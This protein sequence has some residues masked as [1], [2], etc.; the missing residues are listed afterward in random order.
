MEMNRHRHFRSTQLFCRN[1]P[2]ASLPSRV[3]KER[4]ERRSHTAQRNL[5]A[6]TGQGRRPRYHS[7]QLN[8]ENDCAR[9]DNHAPHDEYHQS[10]TD[11][12]QTTP[13]VT[14]TRTPPTPPRDHPSY[15]YATIASI[16]CTS[17]LKL[18]NFTCWLLLASIASGSVSTHSS[19]GTSAESDVYARM[20][21]TVGSSMTGRKVTVE[22]ICLRI[23]RISACISDSGLAEVL[24]VHCEITLTVIARFVHSRL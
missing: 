3:V 21:N 22:T 17:V 12:R 15:R 13:A 18:R 9:P 10:S 20:L 24:A 1:H 14:T 5:H 4:R 8:S 19:A 6:A 23:F 16:R 2:R 7:R 11:R